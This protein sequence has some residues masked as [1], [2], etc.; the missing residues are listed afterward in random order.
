MFA[1]LNPEELQSCF[2]Q[3]MQAV[4]KLTNGE[5]LNVE[6]KTLRGAREAGNNRSFIQIVS[7]CTRAYLS[8]I[9]SNL[10]LLLLLYILIL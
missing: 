1:R 4:H 2:I 9:L 5:L 10:I 6:G 8:F 7:L 3:W